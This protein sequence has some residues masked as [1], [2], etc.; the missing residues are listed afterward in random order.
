MF[1]EENLSLVQSLLHQISVD[2]AAE[3]SDFSHSQ[4][5]ALFGL[6]ELIR[7]GLIE[8][9]FTY[10]DDSDPC[11]PLLKSASKIRLT[12]LGRNFV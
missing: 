9:D 5:D 1:V 2:Q 4:A 10:G 11:G 8:G 12:K 6:R 7:L 3:L